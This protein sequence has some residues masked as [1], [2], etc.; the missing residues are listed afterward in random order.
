MA[1]AVSD[2]EIAQAIVNILGQSDAPIYMSALGL[3]LS[4]YFSR[5]LRE[6]L[7]DRK[8]KAIIEKQLAARIRLIGSLS[9]IEVRLVPEAAMIHPRRYDPTFW[10]AFSKPLTAGKSVRALCP[11][12]PYDFDDYTDRSEVQAGW[13]T[14]ELP[15]GLSSELQKS[16]REQIIKDAILKW[17]LKNN[18][19]PSRFS[20]SSKAR[21]PRGENS[22]RSP[23]SDDTR[24]V[25]LLKFIEN[26]PEEERQ[27]YTL[28][29]DLIY[30]FLK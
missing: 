9:K 11:N 28:P 16:D 14:V 24:V 26:I 12:S 21:A 8:L 27:K 22:A 1:N 4:S 19:D 15:D 6:I 23:T 20:I 3:K 13:K 7:G 17:C 29:I 10:A 25:A 2:E 30:L 18:F 5:P